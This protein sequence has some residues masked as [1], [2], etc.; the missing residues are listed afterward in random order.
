[1]EKVLT[2][3]LTK[4]LILLGVGIIGST[5]IMVKLISRI[6]GSFKP[7]QKFTILYLLVC[8]FFFAII[9]LSA[10]PLFFQHATTAFIFLQV[11][12]LLL[13]CF[14]VFFLNRNAAWGSEEKLFVPE[15]L[16]TVMIS[17]CGCIAYLLVHRW[18]N[19]N[20]LEY[21]MSS[22]ILF[23][24]VPFFFYHAF[25]KALA[26]PPKVLKKWFYPVGEEVEEPE[27]SKLRN[28]LVISFEFQKN[29]ADPQV[30][31]FRAKAPRDMDFGQLFYYFINDYNE[32]HKNS[33]I[34][35]TNGSG[36]PYGWIF[37]RKS[38]WYTISTHYIDAE[39]TIFT[40]HIRENDVI[41]C[42]RTDQ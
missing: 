1:M 35:Y 14:H 39:K 33:K 19:K 11:Y 29:Q 24:A 28:L 31:N 17:L 16:Y 38:K 25:Q 6:K 13:G 18:L 26:I 8:V 37:Y 21:I 10:L 40:N 9:G 2:S 32:M 5:A 36:K 27:D 34:Q 42:A 22:S 15:M 3:E 23:F 20:G 4:Y 7:Y 41:I 30:T 12:F